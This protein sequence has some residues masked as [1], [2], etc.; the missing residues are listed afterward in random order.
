MYYRTNG[1]DKIQFPDPSPPQ[2]RSATLSIKM[3]GRISGKRQRTGPKLSPAP[4]TIKPQSHT[5]YICLGQFSLV[6]KS[7]YT[8]DLKRKGLLLDCLSPLRSQSCRLYE[9]RRFTIRPVAHTKGPQSPLTCSIQGPGHYSPKSGYDY[10]SLV[11]TSFHRATFYPRSI[12]SP[13]SHQG[14]DDRCVTQE[15]AALHA[16]HKTRPYPLMMPIHSS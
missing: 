13:C 9:S 16:T 3:R 10:S 7:I 12:S 2:R 15:S 6:Q 1:N 4:T 8:G 11:C 14:V 5:T